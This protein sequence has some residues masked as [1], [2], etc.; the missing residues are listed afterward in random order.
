MSGASLRKKEPPR[1]C[2]QCGTMMQRKRYSGGRLEDFTVFMKRQYCSRECK[3][4]SVIKEVVG[5]NQYRHRAR[6]FKKSQCER[7]GSRRNLQTH[8]VD[9]DITNNLLENLETLC[10]SCHNTEHWK[11]RKEHGR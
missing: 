6:K 10:A 3:D 2:R 1:F 8:H 9:R 7:C 5:K 4:K 11:D